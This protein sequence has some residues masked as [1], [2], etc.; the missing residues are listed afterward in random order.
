MRT[1]RVQYMIWFSAM[2]VAIGIELH[3]IRYI[4]VRYPPLS[5]IIFVCDAEAMVYE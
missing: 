4:Q 2:G 3:M 5:W 1:C